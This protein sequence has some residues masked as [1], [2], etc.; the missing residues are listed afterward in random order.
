MCSLLEDILRESFS[1]PLASNAI[2]Y[3]K[4]HAVLLT[5]VYERSLSFL[6]S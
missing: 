1:H 5:L 6:S 3:D 2:I 4:Y